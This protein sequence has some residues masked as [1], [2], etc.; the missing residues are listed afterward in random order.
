[1]HKQVKQTGLVFGTYHFH[2]KK[3]SFGILNY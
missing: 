3:S 1:M 2:E